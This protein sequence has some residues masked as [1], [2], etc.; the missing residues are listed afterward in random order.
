MDQVISAVHIVLSIFLMI[1]LGMLLVGIGWLREEHSELISRLVVKVALP[2]MIIN[3]IF[4]RYTRESLL[5]SVVGI[6]IPF[7]SM[8]VTMFVGRIFA[9]VFNIGMGRV[10]VFTCMFTFSN[11]VFIGV[12]V[13]QALF[14]DAVI[15]YT[16]LYYIAN[17]VLFW[18][19]GYA[20]MRKDGNAPPV[21]TDFRAI[22]AYFKA[23]RADPGAMVDARY[24]PARA[25]LDKL[26]KI[27]PI[28]LIAFL[29]CVI[30]LLC[31]VRLPKFVADAS[32]YVGAL[33][34]PLS[35]LY[36]GM[37]LM[38]MIK[39]RRIRWQRGYEWV[40]VGR[41]AVAPL[42]LI[43]SV[44]LINMIASATGI[45]MLNAPAL[46]RNALIIQASMPVMAQT[47]IVAAATGSDEEYAAG[48]I[49]LT[50]ALSL[51]FIPFYMY[52]IATIL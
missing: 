19:I 36:T 39:M 10:G 45:S 3:N 50:T 47:P 8:L 37:I 26:S 48:G 35:L 44:S 49:A 20:M 24:A 14:G 18:T 40:I 4:T 34:T 12:P 15:S 51:V 17:T 41:F 1:G 22:P 7:L 6:I 29:L 23:R 13:S 5:S 16:L 43:G 30:L 52:V 31:N 28:P 46:M 42:L 32:G 27:L 38:R 9:R 33:V 25:A 21:Q 2:S 11:A